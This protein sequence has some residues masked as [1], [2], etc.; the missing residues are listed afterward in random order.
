MLALKEETVQTNMNVF[1]SVTSYFYLALLFR[2]CLDFCS[3]LSTTT[4]LEFDCL[5]VDEVNDTFNL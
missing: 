3:T 1:I 4:T 2:F 5:S